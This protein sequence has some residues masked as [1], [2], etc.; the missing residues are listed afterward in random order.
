[1][2]SA[3]SVK[4]SPTSARRNDPAFNRRFSEHMK[5]RLFDQPL[6]EAGHAPIDA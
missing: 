3:S 6:A 1:M 5:V 4:W 2:H